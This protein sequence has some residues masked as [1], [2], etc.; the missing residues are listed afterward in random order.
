[1]SQQGS[2]SATVTNISE[3]QLAQVEMIRQ[4]IIERSGPLIPRRPPIM[5]YTKLIAELAK[6][7]V[8]AQSGQD[9]LSMALKCL[10]AVLQFLDDDLE[11][12]TA[13]LT[14]PL[15]TLVAAM[16]DVL[17]GERPNLF[18]D[19]PN[20][21]GR[22]SGTTFEAVKGGIAALADA[23]ITWGEPQEVAAKFIAGE[24]RRLGVRVPK[25]KGQ[26]VEISF[27]QVLRWRHEVGGTPSPLAERTYR[28][29]RAKCGQTPHSLI[30]TTERRRNVVRGALQGIRGMGI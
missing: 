29:V 23:L 20:E 30:G 3:F 9:E 10:V 15:G 16:R 21:P 6:A 28:D 18:F 24:L 4:R 12:R 27:K 14:R 22:P 1:M 19:R 11:V 25:R 17:I 7:K 8:A 2:G 13:M 5:R 26:S